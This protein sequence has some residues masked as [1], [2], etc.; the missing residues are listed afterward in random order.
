M[1]LD[2]FSIRCKPFSS[3]AENALITEHLFSVFPYMWRRPVACCVEGCIAAHT[4]TDTHVD[5]RSSD[6]IIKPIRCTP[7]SSNAENALVFRFTFLK[8]LNITFSFFSIR[9]K[10]FS[11]DAENALITPF[12]KLFFPIRVHPRSSAAN[13]FF[14][15]FSYPHSSMAN[16]FFFP[17][18]SPGPLFRFC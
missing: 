2:F 9:C 14:S 15:V 4:C 10:P 1:N 6:L 13:N 18:S 17:L 5:V 11:S 3:N 8:G 7:F 12:L 16:L